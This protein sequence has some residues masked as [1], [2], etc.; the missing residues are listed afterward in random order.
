[1][2]FI[3]CTYFQTTAILKKN[4]NRLYQIIFDHINYKDYKR[5]SVFLT[6]KWVK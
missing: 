1:M 2:F 6:Q 3:F 4:E 5:A